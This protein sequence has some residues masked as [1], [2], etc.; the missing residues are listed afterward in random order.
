MNFVL[1]IGPLQV[2][3]R[4]FYCNDLDLNTVLANNVDTDQTVPVSLTQ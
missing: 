4:V 2:W 3:G 1:A